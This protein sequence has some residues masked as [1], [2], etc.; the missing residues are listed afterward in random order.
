MSYADF[1]LF[2]D[3]LTENIDYEALA[4]MY[5]GLLYRHGAKDGELL[6][7]ACGTGSLAVLL[8]ERGFDVTAAD[9]SK[10][11]LTV[12]AAKSSEVKWLCAD[13]T[14]LPFEGQFDAVVCA[15]DSINHLPDLSAVQ[16][17]FDG[18]YRSLKSGGVF[19]ADLNTPYK[20][21]EVLGNNAYTFDYEGLYCG[22]QNEL[23][24]SDSGQPCRVDMFL[25]FFEENENGSYTRY[26][27]SLSEIAPEPELIV[28][29]LEK[30]GFSEIEVSEYPTG[31]KLTD[32]GEKFTVIAKK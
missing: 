23:D 12:A 4:E 18:V 30:S 31:G 6:D 8:A 19:A 3:R 1:A 13:M 22:W 15:L 2:Y 17:T 25:D 29:M 9:I 21:R 32:T 24:E 28:E 10:E 14:D 16:Q 5:A 27:D 7:L 11:M 26:S 20:H